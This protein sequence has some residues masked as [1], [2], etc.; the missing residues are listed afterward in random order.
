[1]RSAPTVPSRI[2]LKNNLVPADQQK[3][4]RVPLLERAPEVFQFRAVQAS[5]LGG[6]GRPRFG[7][8]DTNGYGN[9]H[10]QHHKTPKPAMRA[11]ANSS[12]VHV[13]PFALAGSNQRARRLTNLPVPIPP[14]TSFS[15]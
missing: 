14:T 12:E 6:G 7:A 11:V 3:G 2:P 4:G 9:P 8:H 13:T 15:S 10:Q 1:M 5:T